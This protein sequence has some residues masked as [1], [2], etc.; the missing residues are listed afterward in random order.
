M[1][2]QIPFHHVFGCLQ[3]GPH[4]VR[5]GVITLISRVITPV[6]HL[7]SA[8]GIWT[9]RDIFEITI[10]VMRLKENIQT[11]NSYAVFAYKTG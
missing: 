1:G 3:G 7:F 6:I 5:N 10:Q 4:P 9:S 2:V 11:R 8:I